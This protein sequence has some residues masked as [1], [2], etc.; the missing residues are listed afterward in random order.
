[1]NGKGWVDACNNGEH[2]TIRASIEPNMAAMEG[3]VKHALRQQMLLWR[4]Q[5][6]K[7]KNGGSDN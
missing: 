4:L 5:Q 3:K 6:R 7:K 2:I 1:M